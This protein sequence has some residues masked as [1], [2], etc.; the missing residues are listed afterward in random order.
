MSR[1]K[2]KRRI[3]AAI[4]HENKAELK[5]ALGYCEMRVKAA[6]SV[7]TMRKQEKYWLGMEKRV[8][9]ALEPNKST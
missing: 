7:L 2:E 9:E 4:D 5:W 8:R 6:R 1:F 3:D